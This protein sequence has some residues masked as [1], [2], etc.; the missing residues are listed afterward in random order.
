M[1]PRAVLTVGEGF[2]FMYFFYYYRIIF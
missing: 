2:L 1:L